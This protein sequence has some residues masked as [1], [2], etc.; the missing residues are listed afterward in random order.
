MSFE[1]VA[2]YCWPQSVAPGGTV[3]LH[4]SSAGS[5]DVHVEIARVGWRREVVWAD[6]V[7]AG[8]HPTPLDASANGCGWPAA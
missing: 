4:L 5:R 8:D 2:G 7:P 1:T 6:T 3:A